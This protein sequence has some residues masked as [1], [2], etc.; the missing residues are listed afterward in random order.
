MHCGAMRK[1]FGADN[2]LWVGQTGRGWGSVGGK[3]FGLERIVWDEKTT[4]MEMHHVSLTNDGFTIVFTKPVDKKTAADAA[5][6][7]IKHWGYE[8]RAEYGSPKVGT[9]DVSRAGSPLPRMESLF[10][11]RWIS[12]RIGFTSS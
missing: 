12:S 10:T 5:S 1:R 3:R 9:T 11:C 2:A 7:S 6:Y 8:Y 4:P